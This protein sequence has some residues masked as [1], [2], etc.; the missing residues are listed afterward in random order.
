MLRFA[1]TQTPALKEA[2]AISTCCDIR[3]LGVFEGMYGVMR[4]SACEF[5][6][7]A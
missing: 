3:S 6:W 1:E 4:C 7:A 2:S 5:I